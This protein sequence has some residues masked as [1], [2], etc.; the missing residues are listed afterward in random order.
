MKTKRARLTAIAMAV[1]SLVSVER[2]TADTVLAGFDYFITQ[3]G[4]YADIPT[5]GVVD[6]LG[7]PISANGADTIVQR[8]NDVT[9]SGTTPVQVIALSLV[10]VSGLGTI[11]IGLDPAQLANDTGSMTISGTAAGGTFTSFFDV[12]FEICT[13]PSVDG[14]GCTGVVLGTGNEHFESSGNWI[15]P[16]FNVVGPLKETA[17][18]AVHV[19]NAVPGPIAGAGLPGLALACGGLLGWW[20]RKHNALAARAAA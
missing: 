12:F 17:P 14:I 3:P 18:D 16:G 11:Y 15:G 4:T 9:L 5:L 1:A 6:F 13:G 10:S 8:L 20:R 7:S 19:V 2:A